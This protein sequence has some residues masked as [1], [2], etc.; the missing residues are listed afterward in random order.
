M[1]I[2]LKTSTD[3]PGLWFVF[4]YDPSFYLGPYPSRAAAEE[5]RDAIWEAYEYG[6]NEIRDGLRELIGAAANVGD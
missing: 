4:C 6:R 2:F 1:N 5:I 3:T